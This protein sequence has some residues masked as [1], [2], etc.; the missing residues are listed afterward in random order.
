MRRRCLI[1]DHDA[2]PTPKALTGMLLMVLTTRHPPVAALTS[3]ISM[4]LNLHSHHRMRTCRSMSSV[5]TPS[6]Y[7]GVVIVKRESDAPATEEPVIF[8]YARL[9]HQRRPILATSVALGLADDMVCVHM[10]AYTC[11]HM[12]CPSHICCR[13]MPLQ[14]AP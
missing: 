7:C 6:E 13:Y 5:A 10:H 2:L 14:T 11:I 8:A 9:L 3:D 4:H 12:W 1:P